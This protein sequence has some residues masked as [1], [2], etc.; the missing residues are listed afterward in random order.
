MERLREVYHIDEATLAAEEHGSGSLTGDE[1]AVLTEQ[2]ERLKE[3]LETA[4]PVSMGSVEEYDELAKRLDFLKTQ[5]ED[6]VK[7][8]DDLRSTIQQINRNARQQFRETF[9]TIR[10][11][12]QGYFA[13]LFNG[14]QADLILLNEEDVLESGIEIVARPPGKRLQSISLLSGGERAMTAVALLFSFFKVRP[15]PFCILDELDAPL[16]EANVDRFTRVLEEFLT[17]SQFILITH[18]K[19]TI[20]KADCLYGVTME[21]PGMSKVVSVKL[22]KSAVAAAQA[23]PAGA[24]TAGDVEK[25]AETVNVTGQ[26][27]TSGSESAEPV[28]SASGSAKFE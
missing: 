13:K 22:K 11:E 23:A 7:A 5:H 26:A 24:A 15:S 8:R 27:E 6:L 10:Q 4:G 1:R 16:D 14:G 17:L 3:K 21:Q 9:N 2:I 20:S 19:K 28:A 12:F 18:N 25:S